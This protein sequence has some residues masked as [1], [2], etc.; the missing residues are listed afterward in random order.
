MLRLLAQMACS[1]SAEHCCSHIGSTM[2]L[3]SAMTTVP[4][5]APQIL[6]QSRVWGL[7]GAHLGQAKAQ[8]TWAQLKVPC[9][10]A[11]G[12]HGGQSKY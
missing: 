1:T 4:R 5:A 6:T 8:E 7:V 3:A 9:I 11:T 2:L 12:V 10:E